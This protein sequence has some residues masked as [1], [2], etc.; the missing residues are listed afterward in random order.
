MIPRNLRMLTS[1]LLAAALL[2]A[3][4]AQAEQKNIVE[5]AQAAGQ[6]KTL[7]AAAEAAG[8]AE[9]LASPGPLT[10]FAPTDEAFGKL[11]KGTVE[12]LL[13][14][15]NRAKLA[16]ILKYHVVAGELT[17]GAVLRAGKADT[18]QGNTV[19]FQAAEGGARIDEANILKTD[20]RA[21]NGIIHVIDRVILPKDLVARLAD[22][23]RFSTLVTAVKAA[24][25]AEALSG[26]GSLTVFAPTNAAFDKL[27]AGA[28]GSLLEPSSRGKL[29]EILKLHVSSG[30]VR[31]GSRPIQT[32]QGESLTL[33]QAGG[34]IG[35]VAIT[36]SDIV[37]SN[38][39]IHVIDAV[40]LPPAP[41]MSQ[42]DRARKLI[43]TAIARGAPLYNHGN[44]A[45]CAAIYEVAA[46]ALLE[47]QA[48]PVQRHREALQTALARVEAMDHARSEA[49]IL[50]HALD[51]V[52]RDLDAAQ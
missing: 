27:P 40:L 6:F 3:A 42:S 52:Y 20:I 44:A 30:A 18:L 36:Q 15:E 19:L 47:M 11:P 51:R 2:P 32:L 34:T 9:A 50:R 22:D 28:L 45:A 23:G 38:G 16:A 1:L 8:L 35:G 26:Q 24:G 48:A 39:I 25:L 14:P 41:K 49:W 5:T 12:N 37:T 31:V 13:K 43:R 46:Q 29:Q 21:S 10:V 7:L 4:A 33:A 17:A